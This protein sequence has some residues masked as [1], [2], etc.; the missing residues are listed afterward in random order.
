MKNG[1]L[2]YWSNGTRITGAKVTNEGFEGS[3]VR[4]F[5]GSRV[6]GKNI[7]KKENLSK[8]NFFFT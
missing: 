3:R 5:E 1:V 8:L 6:R 2:E 7:I 4:G